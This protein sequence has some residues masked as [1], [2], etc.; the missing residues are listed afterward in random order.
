MGYK[1][2]ITYI[3]DHTECGLTEHIFWPASFGDIFEIAKLPNGWYSEGKMILCNRHTVR[4]IPGALI[5]DGIIYAHNS[6]LGMPK[7]Y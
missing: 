7:S 2:R 5:V 3:C 4:K 1:V 6:G